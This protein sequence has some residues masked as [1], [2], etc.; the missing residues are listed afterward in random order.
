MTDVF[1]RR[2]RTVLGQ[3]K[4]YLHSIQG[5]WGVPEESINEMQEKGKL[6]KKI[7]FQQLVAEREEAWCKY[8]QEHQKVG[9][10][11]EIPQ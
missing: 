2:K 11:S 6:G 10:H 3:K 7:G 4:S 1:C 5:S 8:A 9:D